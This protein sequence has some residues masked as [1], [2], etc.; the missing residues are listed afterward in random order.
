MD[1]TLLTNVVGWT[2][3]LI[4]MATLVRQIYVQHRERS[5]KGVS[6]WLFAGQIGASL[7]FVIYS[8]LV[9]NS[10][11]IA[12]NIATLLI[13]LTGQVLYLRQQRKAGG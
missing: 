13:A 6:A 2:S 5:L 12:T 1:K 3:S 10:V 11:F 7:G 8:L 9:E 4:L